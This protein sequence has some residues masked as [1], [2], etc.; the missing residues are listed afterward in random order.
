MNINEPPLSRHYD[1]L[2]E[3][4]KL[5][6]ACLGCTRCDLRKGCNRVVF[7]DGIYSARLML[8][9][10]GPGAD[11]DKAGIPFVGRAGQLLD[12]ILEA[13]GIDRKAIYITNIV[14]CRPPGNRL[15]LQP[16]VDSCLPYLKKQL[17]LIKP[18]ILVC[19]G[20]L[21]TKTLIDKNAA[22]TRTRGKWHDI[23]GRRVI[24]T[25]H[26]AA[27]LRDPSK[28]KDVWEDFKQIMKLY[29]T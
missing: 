14:K 9:G 18:E 28:K 3:L 13:A 23:D 1:P 26:P 29:N 21:A 5:K 4:E 10:E 27:L 20:G 12:R 7:G 6:A 11:E 8:V 16:E 24:A 19:L 15:P 2:T 25:F 17:E 22:V